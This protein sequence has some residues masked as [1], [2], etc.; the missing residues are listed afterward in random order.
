MESILL[1]VRLAPRVVRPRPARRGRRAG[2]W[3]G[4]P[5]RAPGPAASAAARPHSPIPLYPFPRFHLHVE[6]VDVGEGRDDPGAD[7]P[8]ALRLHQPASPPG[9][10]GRGQTGGA[11]GARGAGRV[12]GPRRGARRAQRLELGLELPPRLQQALQAPARERHLQGLAGGLI[13]PR[14][15]LGLLEQP[16]HDAHLPVHRGQPA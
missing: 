11:R 15:R 14:R 8:V 13:G 1:G 5:G 7:E 4:P 16:A 2:W 3:R 10:G 12:R 9:V 6:P